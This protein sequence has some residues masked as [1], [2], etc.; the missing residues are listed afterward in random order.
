MA[1]YHYAV[2]VTLRPGQDVDPVDLILD[3][4][5]DKVERIEIEPIDD[6]EEE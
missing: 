6:D 3:A 1:T 5:R 4:L 2:T